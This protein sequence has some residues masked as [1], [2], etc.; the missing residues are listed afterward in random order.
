MRRGLR[1]DDVRAL[2]ELPS[3]DVPWCIVCGKTGQ[4]NWHHDPWKSETR[5]AHVTIPLCGFGN[6]SG[7]HGEAHALKLHF[8]NNDGRW[9]FLRLDRPLRYERAIEIDEGWRAAYGQ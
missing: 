8:R 7:C 6:T 4:L 9:E 3:V 5:G 1:D 2:E